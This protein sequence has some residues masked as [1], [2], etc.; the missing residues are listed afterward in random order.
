MNLVIDI[1]NTRTK[2][3]LYENNTLLDVHYYP[4]FDSS[5]LKYYL[6]KHPIKKC[7]ISSVGESPESYALFLQNAGIKHTIIFDEQTPI[8][9][10]NNYSTPQ[11]LGK[12]R[13]AG[14]IG[15][16]AEFASQ[17]ILVIDAGTCVTY[18]FLR[19]EGVYEGGAISPGIQMRLKAVNQFTKNL[20]LVESCESTV[21][22]GK[23][24]EESIVSGTLNSIVFEADGFIDYYKN[25]YPDL[26][27]IVTGGDV[28]YFDKTL[29]NNIF[30]RPNIVLTGLNKILVYY[31][32]K[33]SKT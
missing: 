22:T 2:I 4:A 7:I 9:I 17:D 29:K 32:E 6:R 30:A 16:Y 10:I 20:P 18:D 25:L 27:T 13:L 1:G 19:K 33:K 21:V 14:V 31:F 12:D 11:T 8:P 26:I 23:T 5:D 3:G 15:A 24:T 28:N